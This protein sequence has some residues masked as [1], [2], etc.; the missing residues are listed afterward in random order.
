[1]ADIFVIVYELQVFNRPERWRDLL[2][3]RAVDEGAWPFNSHFVAN[4]APLAWKPQYLW[5]PN[6]DVPIQAADVPTYFT[7]KFQPV[8]FARRTF[9]PPTDTPAFVTAETNRNFLA[10]YSPY[11]WNQQYLWPSSNEVPATTTTFE[12]N[13]FFLAKYAQPLWRQQYLWP[14]PTDASTKSDTPVYFLAKY[15]S[16]AWKAQYLWSPPSDKPI[17]ASD[18]PTYFLAKFSPTVF[19]RRIFPQ[20]TDAPPV[21]T[22]DTP[23]YFLARFQPFAWKPQ[24]LWVPTEDFSTPSAAFATNQFFLARYSPLVFKFDLALRQFASVDGLPPAPPITFPA[25][26]Y[27]LEDQWVDNK[28]YLPAGTI[29]TT[30]D[31]GGVLPLNWVPNPNVD[32]VDAGA[33]AAYTAVGYQPRGLSRQQYTSTPVLPPN[34]VWQQIN[35]LWTLVKVASFPRVP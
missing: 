6:S 15:T 34:Y 21:V 35:G 16:L 20:P 19:A 9:F 17:P 29:Q 32:P 12:T 2:W 7:A 25:T 10:Q 31:L 27:M 5:Q 1:M 14:H 23:T 3:N 13:Q 33:V 11:Q 30:Q 28:F 22:P 26:Y 8:Q 24:Y 18:V 4:Y